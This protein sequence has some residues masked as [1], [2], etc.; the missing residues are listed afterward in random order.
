MVG[1]GL[2]CGDWI[3]LVAE[4]GG[5]VD[6]AEADDEARPSSSRRASRGRQGLGQSIPSID[7]S[8]ASRSCWYGVC[9]VW[10][11]GERALCL[12]LDQRAAWVVE[13]SPI[14]NHQ[15]FERGWS[16]PEHSMYTHEA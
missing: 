6:V 4:V 12:G 15:I 8:I 14:S 9:V 13:P 10:G 2:A 5:C 3:G 1:G 7:R 16:K 11:G